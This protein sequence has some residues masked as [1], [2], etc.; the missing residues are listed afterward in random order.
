[1]LVVEIKD[2]NFE[3]LSFDVEQDIRTATEELSGYMCRH[4]TL[5]Q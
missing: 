4:Q 1:M 2:T 3:N 5:D